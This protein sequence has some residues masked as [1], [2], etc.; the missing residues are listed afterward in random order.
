MANLTFS[1]SVHPVK[2]ARLI[3]WL[4][5]QEN[6]SAA[7]RDVLDAHVQ[8]EVRVA[9]TL[10]E[11]NTSLA[12]LRSEVATLKRRGVAVAIEDDEGLIPDEPEAATA[13][14][15]SLGIG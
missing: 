9:D 10:R 12:V 11:I 5:E 3:A 4:G 7:I 13:A 14:L 1:F 6:A 15:D 8:G 2:H